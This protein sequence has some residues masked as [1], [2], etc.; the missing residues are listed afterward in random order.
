VPTKRATGIGKES[1]FSPFFNM[2]SIY[3]DI[4]SALM[5]EQILPLAKAKCNLLNN[6][7]FIFIAG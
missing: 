4:A 7:N 6:R 1:G 2:H 3:Q 5:P